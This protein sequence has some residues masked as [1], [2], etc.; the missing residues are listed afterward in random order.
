MSSKVEDL[1][2]GLLATGISYFVNRLSISFAYHQ[3]EEGVIF[4]IWE[5]LYIKDLSYFCL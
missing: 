4:Y 3:S 5:F 1:F 2:I